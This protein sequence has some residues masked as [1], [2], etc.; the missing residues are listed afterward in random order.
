MSTVKRITEARS[1]S[2]CGKA[3]PAPL[4]SAAGQ[5]PR[6][7]TEGAPPR[8][9]G[10]FTVLARLG[11]GGMG[12]VYKCSQPDLDRPVAV[13]VVRLRPQAEVEQMLRFQ[14]EVRAASQLAHPNIVQIFD[15]G[16]EDT[17]SYFVM[18]FVDGPSLDRLIGTPALTVERSLC[19]V[20]HVAGAVAAA[21]AQGILHR[22][23][24]PSNVILDGAGRP[25]LA[26]FG[27]AKSLWE[28]EP[29]SRT[30]DLLGTPCYMSPEQA[31]EAAG[32]VDVRSDVYSL[33]AVLYELLTG[34]RPVEGPTLM[35]I[36]YKLAE[37]EPTSVRQL[38]P[39][40][41]VEVE[42]ICHRAMAKNRA[43]RYSSAAELADAIRGFMLAPL[44]GQPGE[45]A[46]ALP[47]L[48]PE[49]VSQ[50]THRLEPPTTVRWHR[51]RRFKALAAGAA[52][53]LVLVAAAL[54]FQLHGSGRNDAAVD[55]GARAKDAQH[56]TATKSPS[57]NAGTISSSEL[58]A[59][60]VA[61]AKEQLSQ[62]L[63]LPE[64]ELRRDRLRDAI[65]DLS[66]ALRRL[67]DDF[68]AQ[69]AARV[70]ARLLRARAL[71]ATGEN[72]AAIDDLNQVLRQEPRNL[73]AVTERLLAA[74]Q[75]QVL[76][77]GTAD[78]PLLRP[79]HVARIADDVNLLL[80]RGDSVQKRIARL[81]DP[82]A[83]AEFLDAARGIDESSPADSTPESLADLCMLEADTLLRGCDEL[84]IEEANP[85]NPERARKVERRKNW[86]VRA[87]T[88]LERGLVA[89]PNHPGLLFLKAAMLVREGN[90]TEDSYAAAW[91][92]Y[93]GT[94]FQSAIKRMRKATLQSGP[95]TPL[96][97][98]VLLFNLHELEV[99]QEHVNVALGHRPSE[100]MP[101]VFKV[102]LVLSIPREAPLTA[103]DVDRLTDDMQPA[104]EPPPK[105]Y[106]PFFARALL[107]AVAGRWDQARA[108][109]SE[110]RRRLGKNAP[111]DVAEYNEWCDRANAPLTQFYFATLGA[112]SRV[113]VSPDVSEK[114]AEMVLVRLNDASAIKRDDV[115]ENELR[116]M[117]A[118]S[119]F[120]LAL[121][122]AELK[123]RE[124]TLDHLRQTVEA[125]LDELPPESL[126]ETPA[127]VDWHDDEAFVQMYASAGAE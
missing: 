106:N 95:D 57:R 8:A 101:Y 100:A 12:V 113:G 52:C 74:Y 54:G 40:V 7:E 32:D 92:I 78:E 19:V 85:E 93:R 3:F 79:R 53:A 84:Y 73:A 102:W 60:L 91:K 29:L 119:H 123:D 104:F 28:G 86:F 81:I 49:L 46:A 48:V 110:C 2:A 108:D 1:C 22:D 51:P 109:L 122:S 25:K 10:K 20:Y 127:F 89:N 120:H 14:R 42:A 11:A 27:L 6:C 90:W 5:C 111:T 17:M 65:E 69:P 99:A 125:R 117:K 116:R 76:Y 94:A 15:V 4:L 97:Q 103:A 118:L 96:A 9:I 105:D 18:E 39:N 62:S 43:E 44:M 21:H 63:R 50:R 70:E 114:L 33:G 67:P 115:G 64:P 16:R 31:F 87:Q 30:G 121:R 126:R 24:K 35:S 107:Q 75:I 23:I 26:D 68:D 66:A 36:L 41:P 112:I 38:N 58:A 34:R 37:E 82:L 13:K 45:D 47:A 72:L 98:A 56:A 88:K 59:G 55:D 71:R 80:E 83:R 124:K 61:Q 77:L